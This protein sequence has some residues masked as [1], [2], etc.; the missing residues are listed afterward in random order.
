MALLDRCS[1]LVF[2][3]HLIGSHRPSSKTQ[4]PTDFKHACAL[5]SHACTASPYSRP[6]LVDFHHQLIASIHTPCDLPPAQPHDRYGHCQVRRALPQVRHARHAAAG[7]AGEGAT[8]RGMRFSFLSSKTIRYNPQLRGVDPYLKCAT[9]D[10]PLP[11]SL[12]RERR[13]SDSPMH[14]IFFSSLLRHATTHSWG[15]WTYPNAPLRTQQRETP[16]EKQGLAI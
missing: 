3:R 2:H 16:W 7:I 11:A 5:Q 14:E 8:H 15:G 1:I 13:E 9:R 10:T 4:I 12:A 6:Y